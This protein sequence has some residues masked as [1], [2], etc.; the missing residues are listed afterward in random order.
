MIRYP[1][2]G[3]PKL[4][5]FGTLLVLLDR[6]G[7]QF[8]MVLREGVFSKA[9]S[10]LLVGIF[11]AFVGGCAN[12]SAGSS[13]KQNPPVAAS[14]ATQPANQ[15]VTA[16][17]RATFSVAATGTAPLN[18]QW[19]RNGSNITGATAAAYTTPATT[20]A[21]D[22][23]TF[24][25]VVSNS[26]GSATS[27]PAKLTVTAPPAP[28]SIT[29][30]PASQTVNAGQTATFSVVATGTA[31]LSYQWQQNGANISGATAASYTIPATT[32]ANNGAT[33][34]VLVSN[35]AGSV[36]SSTAKLTVTAAAVPPS[37]TTQPANQT[38]TAGQT[39]TF[40]VAA[41]GTAPLS[42]QWRQNG[43][44]ISGAIAASYTTPSTTSAN[45]GATF[46]VIVSNSAGSATSNA[47]TLTVTAAA[48]PPSITTQP[49]NQTVTAGQAA[50]FSVVA[51]GTAPLTYQWL[52][53][54]GSGFTPISGATS[55]SYT[56]PAT[57]SANNGMAFE[58][59]A[60]NSAGSVTSNSA[61][62]TVNAQATPPSITAQPTDQ[63]VTAGQTATFSV[64]ASGTAPL[65]YQ[66]LQ[67]SGSGFTPIS[68][69]TSSSYTTPAT[70]SGDN[71]T[72]FEVTVSNSAG[73]VT[74]S[75]A[76]LNIAA[77]ELNYGSGFTSTGLTLNGGAAIAGDAF[78]RLTD[79]SGN[80]ARS[81]F[82]S[83]P[84]DVRSFSTTF[85]FHLTNANADGFTFTIQN[86]N[87]DALGSLGSGLGYAGIPNSVAVGFRFNNS[88]SVVG[89]SIN[90][91][92]PSGGADMS[93]KVDLHSGHL[94]KARLNYT[95]T[96]LSVFVTDL[97][98]TSLQFFTS[99]P[100][101]IPSTVG[102]S[103]AYVGFT[104]GDSGQ[105]STQDILSW[106]YSSSATGTSG[107]FIWPVDPPVVVGAHDYSTTA[108]EGQYHTGIDVCPGTILCHTGDPVHASADGTVAA[109]L[110]TSD[111]AQTMCDGS[112]VGSL[113]RDDNHSGNTVIISHS[114]GKFSLYGNMDCV[115]PGIAPGVV[116]SQGA[117][118]G[119]IGNSQYGIRTN[120]W[121]PH[122]H[123]EIKDAGVVGDPATNTFATFTPD[124]PDGYGYHDPRLYLFPISGSSISP[125]AVKVVANSS[126]NV[127]SG[128]DV[129]YSNL[130]FIAP[131]Q[132]FVAFAS[133]AA[134]NGSWYEVY[135]PNSQGAM[136]GW[137]PA[138]AGGLSLASPDS[139]ATK[140]QVT[141]TGGAGQL[142]R[143]SASSSS[144]FVSWNNNT[145]FSPTGVQNCAPTAKIWDGQ[146]YVLIG[147]QNG[148]DEF[149]L[150]LNHYFSSAS[151]CGEPAAPGPATG[152]ASSS[153]LQ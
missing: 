27:N 18:Y 134:P 69:A 7:C 25:V 34:D 46:D 37:I 60:S 68:G 10:L 80:E 58:V 63:T 13:T 56:T 15:T 103:F 5:S 83:T 71:G 135:L 118:I 127:L 120:T 28:P 139:G 99:F 30:Q 23:S 113:T 81:T 6:C 24:D 14:I 79:G 3:R 91:A 4:E 151:A 39:A 131:G 26:A 144:E 49:T 82:F 107:T 47:A 136:S 125:T 111:P 126:L 122:L 54:T 86:N 119:N 89:V 115:W 104:G 114:N 97:T 20:D 2:S 110:V 149:Y 102:S 70:T 90:G 36:T 152:W 94:F 52:Q 11:A 42:Y 98:D 75:A 78:L 65:T 109:V 55:S 29:T 33:F 116:V 145:G 40:S 95:G 48:V 31:P 22:G 32:S 88:G 17:Q 117:R 92:T 137:I 8:A 96:T 132:E 84:V 128:P 147:S 129:N 76:T 57:T 93:S 74:S 105:T 138:S 130:N 1:P 141:N 123:F 73:S 66:W 53:N 19:Q 148:F 112:S 41:T 121:S 21:D 101:N 77:T 146:S 108:F 35:S 12:T 124:L 44:N 133:S 100:I 67:N 43:A 50:T 38:V 150:P 87:A 142:I 45:N 51:S 59:T 153:F 62:L 72:T 140:I 143:P 16:G 64:V 85:T 61:T 9:G 106:S